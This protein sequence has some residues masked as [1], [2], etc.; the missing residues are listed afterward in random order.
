[1]RTD[2][3]FTRVSGDHGISSDFRYYVLRGVFLGD[4]VPLELA[5]KSFPSPLDAVAGLEKWTRLPTVAVSDFFS[6]FTVNF[7]PYRFFLPGLTVFKSN[8]QP[9]SQ[10]VGRTFTVDSFYTLDG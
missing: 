8:S 9:F 1:V 4:L 10:F 5:A 2:R 7:R 6:F 3:S